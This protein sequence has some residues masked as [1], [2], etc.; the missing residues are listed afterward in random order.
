MVLVE[1]GGIREEKK[2][3]GGGRR[4][5]EG[6]RMEEGAG[7]REQGGGSLCDTGSSLCRFWESVPKARLCFS[8]YF[9][10][11]SVSSLKFAL[12]M[13]CVNIKFSF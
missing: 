12:T 2:E 10:T 7:S 8:I 6:G 5:E 9:L 11:R 3:D 13:P 1:G 4:E